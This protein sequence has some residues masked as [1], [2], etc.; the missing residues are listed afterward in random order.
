MRT[1]NGY[2]SNSSSSS[3][4]VYGR[5]LDYYEALDEM[6]DDEK[7]V[8]CILDHKGTSGE[9]EDFVFRMTDHRMNMLE[10]NGIDVEQMDGRYVLVMKEWFNDGGVMDITEPLTGGRI[11]EVRKD[12]SSPCTDSDRDR[13]FARWVKVRCVK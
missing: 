6:A 9:V 8:I 10:K 4:I 1:R 5:E 2:V 12:D 3:F 7:N 13:N 11:F